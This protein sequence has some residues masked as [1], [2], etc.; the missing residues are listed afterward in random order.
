MKYLIDRSM[1][2]SKFT[3]LKS[4]ISNSLHKSQRTFFD[5]IVN[6]AIYCKMLES[7]FYDENT[8]LSKEDVY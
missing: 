7:K 4:M 3:T 6:T 8:I 1:N 2:Q 5:Y